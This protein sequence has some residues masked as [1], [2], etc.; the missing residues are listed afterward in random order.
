[1]SAPK[2]F[3]FTRPGRPPL[4]AVSYA[5][6]SDP[7][8]L[9]IWHHGL[10]E[11]AGRYTKSEW[12]LLLPHWEPHRAAHPHPPS[13]PLLSLS[14]PLL[15]HPVFSDFAAA[16]IAVATYDAAGHGA[17]QAAAATAGTAAPSEFGLVTDWRLLVSDFMFF[18]AAAV[19]GGG[20]AVGCG[21]APPPAPPGTPL[22]LG[23]HSMGG[24]VA[25]LAAASWLG[26]GGGAP[27][28][29]PL[30][31]PPPPPRPALA[32]LVLS[33]AAV[34]VEWTPILRIQAPLGG[35]LASLAPRARLIPA[36][37]PEDMSADAATVAAYVGDPLNFV[38][39]TRARTGNE[40]LKAFRVASGPATASALTC[41]LIAIHGDADRCTSLPAVRRLVGAA[42]SLDKGLVVFPGGF[43]ELLHPW[44]G[45]DI[46]LATL[47]DWMVAHAGGGG[48]GSGSQAKM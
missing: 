44:E 43:H 32:G 5:P 10:G 26:G 15:P 33:S 20:G 19:S 1:M 13:Q 30:P 35:L 6:R 4:A 31:P 8:A 21:G 38:G 23:G 25:T 12:H 3:T 18:A 28:P 48:S 17:T 24:L 27:G 45:Q 7:R 9:L 47:R 2:S 36:V 46:A 29:P 14:S 41:P 11:H 39:K 16:G 22:F 42:A 34:D 40:L 37:R